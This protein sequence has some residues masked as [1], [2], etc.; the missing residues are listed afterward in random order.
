MAVAGTLV[1]LVEYLLGFHNDMARFQTGQTIGMIGGFAVS[2]VG[3]VLTMRAVRDSSPDGSLSYGRA[4]GTGALTSVFQGVIGG[5]LAYVYGTLINPA[6]HELVLEN[7]RQK[8]P[9]DKLHAVEGMLRFFASP[10]WF[11][12]VMVF[13]VPIMGTVFSLIIAAFMKRAPRTPESPPPLVAG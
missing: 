11:L 8:V 6:F 9:A 5:V 2:I 4:V 1:T 13:V 7:A 12:I 3:L 10:L